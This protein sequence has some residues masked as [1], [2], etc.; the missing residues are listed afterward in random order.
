DG[1]LV[2]IQCVLHLAVD[3][4]R[5]PKSEE[6]H[7]SAA[8]LRIHFPVDGWPICVKRFD[9]V[10]EVA[11]TLSGKRDV[12]DL[13]GESGELVPQFKNLVVGRLASNA[14]VLEPLFQIL[15]N[16]EG[17]TQAFVP[18]VH[19]HCDRMSVP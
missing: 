16:A 7:T 6:H 3:L 2:R 11:A 4:Y 14:C 19:S 15:R 5:A 10:C 1:I 12:A 18:S 13:T 17:P 8:T 9:V